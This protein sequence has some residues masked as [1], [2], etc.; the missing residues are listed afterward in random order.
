MG[1]APS[2]LLSASPAATKRTTRRIKVT[3]AERETNRQIDQQILEDKKEMER[4]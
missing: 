3:A 4:R 2:R 1:G